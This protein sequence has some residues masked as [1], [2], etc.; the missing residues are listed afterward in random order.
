MQ[1]GPE[2]HPDG[3]GKYEKIRKIGEGTFAVIYEAKNKETSERVA[4]KKIKMVR[5]SY[6]IDISAI[7]EIQT[8]QILAGSTNI[9]RLIDVYSG[10]ANVNLV[11][12]YLE[13]DLEALIKNKSILFMPSDIK[14]WMLQLLRGIYQCHY[15]WI[16]H[17]VR[18]AAL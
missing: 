17:R 1:E 4:I 7:R 15:H 13:T 10:K 5:S 3:K 12:E 18:R 14:C 2:T 11:L 16:I 6:G 9:I 8:L